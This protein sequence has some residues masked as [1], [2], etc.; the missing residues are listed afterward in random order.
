VPSDLSVHAGAAGLD[1]GRRCVD[2]YA[3]AGIRLADYPLIGLGSV[4]RHQATEEIDTI[5][6]S[7][8]CVLP[9]HAF[10]VKIS[11][12]ATYGRW[13]TSADSMAWSLA[14]RREPSCSATHSSEANCRRFA[15][16]WR[17]R[18]VAAAQAARADQLQL[19][20]SPGPRGAV[21]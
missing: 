10:G 6:R 2:L 19:F 4:C 14:G 5:V 9:L 8:G 21:A 18:A 15:L 20:T 11:G 16:S 3:E 1:A 12:L 7:L 13:L 17:E